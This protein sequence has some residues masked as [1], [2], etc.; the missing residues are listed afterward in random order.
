MTTRTTLVAALLTAALALTGC[1]SDAAD[2]IAISTGGTPAEATTPEDADADRAAPV[3]G[4][5]TLVEGTVSGEVIPL[6]DEPITLTVADG[7]VSGTA[8][9]NG[10]SA[11]LSDGFTVGT[12]TSTRMMCAEDLMAAEDAYLRGLGAVQ[13]ATVDGDRLVLSGPDVELVLTAV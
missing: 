2:D 12:V 9:C 8:A 5:W 11:P 1:A 3:D 7:Q 4:E 10:Y 13:S 6:A